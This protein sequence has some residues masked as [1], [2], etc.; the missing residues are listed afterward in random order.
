MIGFRGTDAGGDAGVEGVEKAAETSLLVLNVTGDGDFG[1]SGMLVREGGVRGAPNVVSS[2]GI[3]SG[4]GRAVSGAASPPPAATV[5]GVGAAGI[6]GVKRGENGGV[7][8][9]VGVP[10][11]LGGAAGEGADAR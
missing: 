6:G 2:G 5:E 10:C 9:R 7:R 3:A 8:C 1:G 4:S 11:L